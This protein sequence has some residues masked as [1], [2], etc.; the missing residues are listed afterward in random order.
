MTVTRLFWIAGR[1]GWRFRGG[2]GCGREARGRSQDRHLARADN[3]A[4]NDALRLQVDDVDHVTLG[5]AVDGLAAAGQIEAGHFIDQRDGLIA[6]DHVRLSE[7]RD[8]QR[9]SRAQ[10]LA[11]LHADHAA[12]K[13]DVIADF[14]LRPP[15]DDHVG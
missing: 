6:R 4:L 2:E 8:F 14:G 10:L 15:L 7:I 5:A 1:S 3:D 11:G 12:A 9:L 13:G